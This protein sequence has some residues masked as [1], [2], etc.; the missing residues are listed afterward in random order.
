MKTRKRILDISRKLFNEKGYQNVRMR[1]I[2]SQLN[3]SV[4]NLTYY[5]KKKED[6]LKTLMADVAPIDEIDE[7]SLFS[8]HQLLGD[9]LTSIKDYLFFFVS[10]EL[11]ILDNEFAKM[12]NEN[13]E[14]LHNHLQKMI[15]QLKNEGYF[16]ED[17]KESTIEAIVE[18]IML[19]H[20]SWARKVNLYGID[21]YPISLFLQYHW[22]LFSP[23]LTTKGHDELN[24]IFQNQ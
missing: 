17:F 12:N 6:I 1:D 20:L 14:S 11:S 13:V 24:Q 21:Y 22:Q 7:I 23:F 8:L 4:G 9:M 2:S 15:M 19:A 18:M 10:D 16:I 3:I 5:F